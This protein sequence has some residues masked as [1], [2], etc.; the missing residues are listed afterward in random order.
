MNRPFL[1]SICGAAMLAG[2]TVGPD[3]KG[4]P[5]SPTS[6]GKFIRSTPAATAEEPPA[7]WWTQLQDPI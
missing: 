4:P 1:I 2:C 7:R 6:Q 5:K 3:Y